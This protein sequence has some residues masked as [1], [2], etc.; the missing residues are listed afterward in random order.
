MLEDTPGAIEAYERALELEARQR[1]APS[2]TSSQL[3]ELSNDAAKLVDLYRRRVELADAGR[4]E[5]RK[6]D[7]LM[8]AANRYETGLDDRREAI[9]LLNEA[10]AVP[11]GRCRGRCSRSIS[12]TR[13]SASGPSCSRTCACRPAPPPTT[14]RGGC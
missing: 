8:R 1:G 5:G 6:Y 9:A 14:R 4:S 10:L 7:L 2:T 12:S 13:A 3:Y 11:A